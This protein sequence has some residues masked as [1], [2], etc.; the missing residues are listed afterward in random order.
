MTFLYFII[1][2]YCSK[3]YSGHCSIAQICFQVKYSAFMSVVTVV[4]LRSTFD[5]NG[6]LHIT[7]I[8]IGSAKSICHRAYM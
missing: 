2:L 3:I 8:F 1:K 4:A 6:Q 5:S 7:R